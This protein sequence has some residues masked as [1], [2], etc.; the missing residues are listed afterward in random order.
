MNKNAITLTT[1]AAR[2][3]RAI[4]CDVGMKG[5]RI[6]LYGWARKKNWNIN[7]LFWTREKRD[8]EP[9]RVKYGIIDNFTMSSRRTKAGEAYLTISEAVHFSQYAGYDLTRD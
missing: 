9:W 4:H 5:L 1:L 8:G 6:L 3:E 7:A 2:L